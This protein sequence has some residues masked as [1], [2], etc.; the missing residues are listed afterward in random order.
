MQQQNR[1][2]NKQNNNGQSERPSEYYTSW[3]NMQPAGH[4]FFKTAGSDDSTVHC[5]YC[6]KSVKQL[7]EAVPCYNAAAAAAAAENAEL[8]RKLSELQAALAAKPAG[9]R[10]R[11]REDSPASTQR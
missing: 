9:D 4:R 2:S 5:E 6:G 7:L 3:V 10:I 11:A 8:K 1:N